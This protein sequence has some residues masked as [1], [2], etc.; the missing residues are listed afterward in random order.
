MTR[1]GPV[2]VSGCGDR[3]SSRLSRKGEPLKSG[4]HV[5]RMGGRRGPYQAHLPDAGG[6]RSRYA[7]G[8]G[9]TNRR[10]GASEAWAGPL[11]QI[12]G[13]KELGGLLI[14]ASVATTGV[15]NASIG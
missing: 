2:G 4:I 13:R 15:Q 5:K 11:K 7:K 1:R 8:A 10:G 9:V 6:I 14:G 12:W 3:Q